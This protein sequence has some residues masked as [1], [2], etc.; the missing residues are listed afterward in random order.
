ML[1]IVLKVLI[2]LIILIKSNGKW[3]IKIAIQ[4]DKNE[5]QI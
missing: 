1:L 4:F 3:K 5:L 2:I